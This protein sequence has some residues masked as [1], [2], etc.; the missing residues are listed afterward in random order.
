MPDLIWFCHSVFHF[1][2]G[3]EKKRIIP[4]IDEMRSLDPVASQS[5]TTTQCP[6]FGESEAFRILFR[7]LK[8]TITFF[9]QLAFIFPIIGTTY[10]TI[11][12]QLL[13]T[14]SAFSTAIIETNKPALFSQST[15]P[16]AA[17][18]FSIDIPLL[19]L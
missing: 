5:S 9:V 1:L 6:Q 10:G 13:C 17:S 18:P 3:Y 8:Q 12:Q 2:N 14:I 11:C 4:S 16:T 15:D 7:S 19:F